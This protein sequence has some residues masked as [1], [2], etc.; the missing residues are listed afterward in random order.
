[1][2]RVCE[3]VAAGDSTVAENSHCHCVPV[4]PTFTCC[5]CPSHGHETRWG[6]SL[7]L[8]AV[9]GQITFVKSSGPFSK[10]LLGGHGWH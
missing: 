8:A 2:G 1:M 4:V 7:G 5:L 6:P 3:V 9:Q 10:H